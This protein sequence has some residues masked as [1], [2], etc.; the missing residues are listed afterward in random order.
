[1]TAPKYAWYTISTKQSDRWIS[2][3]KL[4]KKRSIQTELSQ[5]QL[6]FLQ[7]LEQSG[8]LLWSTLTSTV[9]CVS[10]SL[11]PHLQILAMLSNNWVQLLHNN[12]L[13]Q[14]LTSRLSPCPSYATLLCPPEESSQFSNRGA[15]SAVLLTSLESTSCSH[16]GLKH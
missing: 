1:M 7:K 15:V 13:Q 11:S 9:N 12:K 10:Q 4:Y 16:I 3:L 8:D 2:P 5:L 6:P 14:H